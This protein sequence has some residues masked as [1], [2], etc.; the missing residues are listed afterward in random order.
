MKAFQVLAAAVVAVGMLGIYGL[1]A[2]A[3]NA[4]VQKPA[5]DFTLMDQKGNPVKLSDFKGKVVVLEWTNT[6]CPFVQ[7]HYKAGTMATLAKSYADRN[8]VWLAINSSYFTNQEKNAVWAE[9][10]QIAYPVL[11]DHEG[12]VAKAYGAKSTPHMFVID[13]AGN[14]VYQ[15]A[16]D[17]DASGEKKEGVVNYVAQALNEVLAGKPVSIPETKPYGCSVKYAP[18][19]T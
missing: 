14:I 6:D 15:G 3:Q 4:P 12:K 2:Q 10:H 9:K 5:P 18:T 16:I 11:D 1:R 7:R 8:V 19:A 17:N 13:A